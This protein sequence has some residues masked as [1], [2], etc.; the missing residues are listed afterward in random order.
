MKCTFCL[1]LT[2]DLAVLGFS[3]AE[4]ILKLH[5]SKNNNSAYRVPTIAVTTVATILKS[6]DASA[7][8]LSVD[9]SL[10]HWKKHFFL[11]S[12]S[13]TKKHFCVFT[14]INLFHPLTLRFTTI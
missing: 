13:G 14:P 1:P 11:F 5:A 6:W 10:K 3:M 9:A 2:R 8:D 12:K 7:P 4:E